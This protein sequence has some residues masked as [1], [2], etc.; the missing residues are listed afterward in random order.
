MPALL[1]AWKQV[2]PIG[3]GKSNLH[4]VV[5]LLL[6]LLAGEQYFLPL[7]RRNRQQRQP[8]ARPPA[9]IRHPPHTHPTL[10]HLTRGPTRRSN[11]RGT[12]RWRRPARDEDSAQQPAKQAAHGE[13]QR[14]VSAV[15]AHARM[16]TT[17]L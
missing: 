13:R 12:R 2:L 17:Q 10:R 5:T 14:G 8:S 9:S 1:S 4:L 6:L 11:R 3:L 7:S 16:T 15:T